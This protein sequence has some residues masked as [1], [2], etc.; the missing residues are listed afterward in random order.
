MPVSTRH[1]D[2][3]GRSWASRLLPS[4]GLRKGPWALGLLVIVVGVVLLAA[5]LPEALAVG[6]CI[7]GMLVVVWAG[8]GGGLAGG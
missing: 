4:D 5:G 3:P 1:S 8:G 6:V 7:L 2:R